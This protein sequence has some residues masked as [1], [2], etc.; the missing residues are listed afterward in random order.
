MPYDLIY[1]STTDNETDYAAWLMMLF[2]QARTRRLTF[3]VQWEESAAVCWPEYRNSFAFG[4]VRPPGVKYTEFQVDTSGSVAAHRFMSI[5]DALITPFSMLWSVYKDINPDLMKDR[6]VQLYYKQYTQAIWNQRYRWEA[7]FVGSNQLN[8]H[9]LGVFGNMG[10]MVEELDTRPGNMKPG[11]RYVA[12]SPGE[13]YPL[14]NYQGRVTG[15]IRHFRWNARQAVGKWGMDKVALQVRNAYDRSDQTLFDFLEFVLPNTEYDPKQIF[16]WKGKPWAS[17]YL[18]VIG[19]KIMERKGYRSF[20]WAGSGYDFAPEEDYGRGPAQMVLPS[21]KTLNAEKAM[22]LRVDHK[23]AEPAYLIS[24]DG[25]VTLKTAPNAF[26]YG[27]LGEAGEER[28]KPLQTGN[29]QVTP[30]MMAEEL[31]S[32]ND[33]FLVSLFPS[34]MPDKQTQK[35]VLQTI[36]DANERGIFLAPTLGRQFTEY[37]GPMLDREADILQ[38]LSA[39]K[40]DKDRILPKMPPIMRE[41][42]GE[43]QTVFC[44]PLARALTGQ[45]IAGFM[46]I[47]QFA[48]GVSEATQD[49]SIMD[50]FDFDEALPEMADEFFVPANWMADEK[51]KAGKRQARTQQQQQDNAVKALPGQ[52]AIEKAHAISAKAATGGNIGGTLSGVPEGGMPMMPGQNQP[53][54]RT[55]GQPG[56]Q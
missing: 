38:F 33:A 22:M 15:Y 45:K 30:E 32:V 42:G 18:S 23:A 4:H 28:A 37:L 54:G 10:M 7:N 56:R 17:V 36:E 55:F 47:S 20:P 29:L 31:K 5:C 19:Q 3:E 44:S 21:L 52:A 35:T 48:Q 26:N 49:P 51:K 9:A 27:G 8:W 43:S 14:R 34:L 2:N 12:T 6:S 11:L 46:K 41:A 40:A 16:H 53:G 1:G 24:D 50:A 13:M 39:N 25:L